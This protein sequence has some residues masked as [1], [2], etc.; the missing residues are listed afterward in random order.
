MP[1]LVHSVGTLLHN[2]P[3]GG[4]PYPLFPPNGST[5]TPNPTNT[6][7]GATFRLPPKPLMLPPIATYHNTKNGDKQTV[8]SNPF[9]KDWQ[10]FLRTTTSW[11]QIVVELLLYSPWNQLLEITYKATNIFLNLRSGQH[12]WDV[13]GEHQSTVT[14]VGT[15]L[16]FGLRLVALLSAPHC[17]PAAFALPATHIVPHYQHLYQNCVCAVNSCAFVRTLLCA[18]MCR[19]CAVV[20]TNTTNIDCV[21]Y[22]SLC[23][24]QE[25]PEYRIEAVEVWSVPTK[26]LRV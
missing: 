13:L 3:S 14:L 2:G 20:G 1:L 24:T 12:G 22:F 18:Q 19:V 10:F 23:P 17:A 26:L 15:W 9:C 6:S 25:V 4:S 11:W 8:L 5:Q 16:C 21:A 7:F